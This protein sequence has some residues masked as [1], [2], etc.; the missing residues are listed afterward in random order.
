MRYGYWR[1][2]KPKEPGFSHEF[3][4]KDAKWYCENTEATL[5][6]LHGLANPEA[7]TLYKAFYATV[8][9]YPENPWLG[10]RKGSAYTWLTF[11]DS[12]DIAANLSYGMYRLGLVPDI[13]AEGKTYRFMG[14]QC[15]NRAEYGLTF[16]AN[17]HQSA[18][19]VALYDT[20]GVASIKFIVNQTQLTTI[21]VAVEFVKKYAQLLLEDQKLPVDK[22]QFKTLKNLIVFE[23]TIRDEAFKEDMDLA[24]KAGLTIYT[25]DE[26]VKTG[27]DDLDQQMKEP[28]PD[29]AILFS[30]TSG[31]TGTP[32]GVKLTHKTGLSATFALQT[33]LKEHR[34]KVEDT[35]LSYLPAAHAF[36]G[37]VFMCSMITGMKCGYFGGN[38]LKLTEDA[39]VLKPTFFPSVP[40]LFNRIYGKIKDK[41]AAKTGIGAF[42][43]RKALATKMANLHATGQTTHWFWDRIIFKKVKAL[44][45]GRVRLMVTGS[46]PIAGEVL[47]FLK[48]CF[49]C[50]VP[51][52]YGM[53]ETNAG[54]FVTDPDD[55]QSGHVGGPLQNYKLRLRDIPEMS[56]YHTDKPYPRGEIC[57]WGPSVME[58]YFKE[59][60][61]TQEVLSE[62][63]WL[64]SGDVGMILESGALKIF[65]RAK[66]IFKL[67]QGE[68]IA[69]EKL[70]NVYIQSEWVSQLYVHGD[71][72][73][74]WLVTFVVVDPDRLNAYVEETGKEIK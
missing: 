59:P 17:M 2:D 65:D 36:E 38:V 72:L 68:Y 44:L 16:V 58:G 47:D 61:K 74:D 12:A 22:Q 70:E 34:F 62:D 3:I 1:T 71:S 26:V 39:A 66:N 11:Q 32:K 20:L 28:E 69:P 52:G 67:S 23:N 24:A 6:D 54:T 73:H 21:S 42:L 14:I 8:Q 35:Y 5:E 51:E 27:C 64:R 63:G 25:F 33:H 49:C 50:V 41:F 4:S 31:T 13:E 19:T 15:K 46:A 56:Y 40:R 9:K 55:P 45:G 48:V 53:T 57:F 29:T 30:Y 18:T 60:E 37:T 7:D 10:T 43:I